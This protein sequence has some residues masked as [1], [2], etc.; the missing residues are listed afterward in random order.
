[1]FWVM[2]FQPESKHSVK[3]DG[4]SSCQHHVTRLCMGAVVLNQMLH[5]KLLD[6]RTITVVPH[7]PVTAYQ[8]QT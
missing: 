4:K 3:F 7:I 1:M 6:S 2:M 8:I 5:G